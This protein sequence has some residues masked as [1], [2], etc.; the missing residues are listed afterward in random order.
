M[1]IKVRYYFD[2]LGGLFRKL[3]AEEMIFLE[4][5]SF[6]FIFWVVESFHGH[7]N[8][9]LD[10]TRKSLIALLFAFKYSFLFYFT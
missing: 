5:S 10:L 8:S 7:C 4:L 6:A 2:F 9:L 3:G 1:R